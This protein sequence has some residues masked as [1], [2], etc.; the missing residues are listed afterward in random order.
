MLDKLVALMPVHFDWKVEEYSELHF[1]RAR[2][3]GL[4]AQD[5]EQGAP[6]LGLYGDRPP[7]QDKG[8]RRRLCRSR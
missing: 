2:S 1:G 8:D 5:V 6:R 3:F 7:I 4:I